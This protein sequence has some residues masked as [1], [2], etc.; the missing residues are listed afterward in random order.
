MT[1]KL[2]LEIQLTVDSFSSD[3]SNIRES[4]GSSVFSVNRTTVR[5]FLQTN[6]IEDEILSDIFDISDSMDNGDRIYNSG[7]NKIKSSAIS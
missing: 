3:K 4:S 1:I 7:S 5:I 2:S 6:L